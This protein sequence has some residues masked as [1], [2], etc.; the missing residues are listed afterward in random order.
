MFLTF[1]FVAVF[2]IVLL[3]RRVLLFFISLKVIGSVIRNIGTRSEISVLIIPVAIC[4]FKKALV[5]IWSIAVAFVLVILVGLLIRG[6]R[7]F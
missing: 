4:L 3:L 6:I 2:I 1:S 5:N 7:L